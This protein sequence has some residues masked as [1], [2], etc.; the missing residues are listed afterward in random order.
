MELN[1]TGKVVLVSGAGRGIGREIALEF[2]KA[3]LTVLCV[4]K[5]LSSCGAVADEINANGGKAEAF[6]VDVSKSAEVKE[7]C[8]QIIK[9]YEAVD[10]IVNNAG[11]TR[12][13]LLM[14]MTDEEWEDVISTNL[15]SCFYVV[16][17][18]VRAM[19]GNRRGRIINIASVSGQAGNAGQ[20]NYAA[21]KAGIIGFTKSLAR[22]LAPRNITAN[23]VAPG[24]IETDMTAVLPPAIVEAA[25]NNIPLKRTGCVS[26][27]AKVC[28]FLASDE[29]N[30]I[31]GQTIAVNGGLYM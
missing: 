21:A 31:T 26:D 28:A 6:A 11:I 7:M 14:R 24:F 22:E 1:Y 9:K 2:A 12:D 25:K 13:N 16:R 4:S 20:T 23:V 10:I 29:A 15:S 5:N 19:M 8:T 30:Y 17:N 3:G 18:L 27:I